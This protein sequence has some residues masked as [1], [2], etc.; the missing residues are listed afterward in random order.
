[1]KYYMMGLSL[2]LGVS[3]GSGKV[4]DNEEEISDWNWEP[5]A[6]DPK[7]SRGSIHCETS[8][9]GLI[10]FF[11]SVTAND[12]QGASDLK[13]GY[14]RAYNQAGQLVVEDV[15]YCDGT[16]CINSF[17]AD[18]YQEIACAFI[19]DFRFTGE[20]FDYSG[21]STGEFD[22]EALPPPEGI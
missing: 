2:L 14:W 4:A 17:H 19:Q 21:N 8:E 6:T 11:I 16:E 13:D 7:I 22:L 5:G 3:C 12:P 20:V 15:L 18:Q 10:L 1:M 9:A